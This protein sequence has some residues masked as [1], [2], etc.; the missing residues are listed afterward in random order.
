[1]ALETT[2]SCAVSDQYFVAV[3]PSPF[4]LT[5][6]EVGLYANTVTGSIDLSSTKFDIADREVTVVGFGRGPGNLLVHRGL[7]RGSPAAMVELYG[8]KKTPPSHMWRGFLLVEACADPVSPYLKGSRTS[9]RIMP[10]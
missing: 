1:M 5:G 2:R 9:K 10:I 3:K 6:A 8:H 4:W 7:A